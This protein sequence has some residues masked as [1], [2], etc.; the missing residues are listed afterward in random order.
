MTSLERKSPVVVGPRIQNS[1]LIFCAG[2]FV[3]LACFAVAF[4]ADRIKVIEKAGSEL[5]EIPSARVL[6]S[7]LIKCLVS[8][9]FMLV[10]SESSLVCIPMTDRGKASCPLVRSASVV[11]LVLKLF[12][13][14]LI[15]V[16]K[17]S[18]FPP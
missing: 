11:V 3:C 5:R 16:S 12:H 17:A 6:L 4:D 1:P 10:F 15:F 9:S 14:F 18:S 7:G 13:S 8:F 2:W